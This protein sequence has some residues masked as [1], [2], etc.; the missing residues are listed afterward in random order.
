MYEVAAG[1]ARAF[2]DAPEY[3]PKLFL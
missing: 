2:A 1:R 3:L